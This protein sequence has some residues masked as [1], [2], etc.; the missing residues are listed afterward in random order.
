MP[1]PK[2]SP[3]AAARPRICWAISGGYSL[4]DD[5]SCPIMAPDPRGSHCRASSWIPTKRF[6]SRPPI[7]VRAISRPA[8]PPLTRCKPPL[9]GCEGPT[10]ADSGLIGTVHKIQTFGIFVP[11]QLTTWIYSPVP[12]ELREGDDLNLPDFRNEAALS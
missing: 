8:P 6:S 5:G 11:S 1:N 9:A 2:T 4:Q 12:G 7:A 10:A 3:E